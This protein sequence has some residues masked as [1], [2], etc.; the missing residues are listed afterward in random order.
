MR[1]MCSATSA[2]R[3][4]IFRKLRASGTRFRLAEQFEDGVILGELADGTGGTFFHNRNDLDVGMQR[5]MA[6]PE[7]SY[8]LGFSPQNLK[9]D[10]NFHTLESF[11]HQ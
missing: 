8:V 11:A 6:A 5:A 2:S 7:I 10:G 4:S 1:P 3:R 9:I